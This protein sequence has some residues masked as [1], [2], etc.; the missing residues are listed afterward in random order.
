MQD[1][2]VDRST[3]KFDSSRIYRR[4]QVRSD[5]KLQNMKLKQNTEDRFKSSAMGHHFK[6]SIYFNLRATNKV[7]ELDLFSLQG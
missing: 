1:Y 5:Q 7:S 2:H 6:S 4:C 3:Q